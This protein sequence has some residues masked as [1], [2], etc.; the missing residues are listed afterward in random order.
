MNA[1]S[2]FM[3][4]P[5]TSITQEL[6]QSLLDVARAD[7]RV[8]SIEQEQ[9]NSFYLE[10]DELESGSYSFGS[11]ANHLFELP[12]EREARLQASLLPDIIHI[13]KSTFYAE[14]VSS[15]IR[16]IPSFTRMKLE[17]Y[18]KEVPPSTLKA[19]CINILGFKLHG[20]ETMAERFARDHASIYAAR[21][22]AQILVDAGCANE[23]GRRQSYYGKVVFEDG[24]SL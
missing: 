7:V 24:S 16:N 23:I 17:N 13:K 6:V 12:S 9:E 19:Q 3:N 5:K 22:H 15:D 21:R 14:R 1:Y 10:A 18:T 4:I 11:I 8:K 20:N 2:S